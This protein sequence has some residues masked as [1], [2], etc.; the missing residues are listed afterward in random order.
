MLCQVCAGW[1]GYFHSRFAHQSWLVVIRVVMMAGG[2]LEV[3]AL[4]AGGPGETSGLRAGD[5]LTSVAGRPADRFR[6]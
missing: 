6:F 5:I 3:Q 4:A 2:H 1:L